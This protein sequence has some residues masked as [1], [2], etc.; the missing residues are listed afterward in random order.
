M[1][2]FTHP[3]ISISG[4]SED[5]SWV[6]EGGTLDVQP[7]F[8]GDPLFAGHYSLIDVIC[9]FTVNVDMD[10]ITSFGTG[11]Y[12]IKL[13]FPAHDNILLSDGCFHD[14]SGSDQY[15]VLG[16]V[17]AGSDIMKLFSVAS[18]GR[19]VPFEYNVPVTLNVADNF[20]IRG[21]YEIDH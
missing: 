19:H 2:R 11:Q 10:N 15:A 9:N 6:I 5:G 3:A 12:Y 20:H 18:N 13:P 7:T 1:A 4:D 16:H 21:T 8:S 14:E 17:D